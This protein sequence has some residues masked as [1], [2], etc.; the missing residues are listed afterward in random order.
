M[1]WRGKNEI[2]RNKREE[3]EELTQRMKLKKEEL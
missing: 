3:W 2:E 1:R